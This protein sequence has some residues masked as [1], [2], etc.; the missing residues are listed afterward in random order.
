MIGQS[1]QACAPA[2]PPAVPPPPG[3]SVPMS[4]EVEDILKQQDA[5]LKS[6]QHQIHKLLSAQNSQSSATQSQRATGGNATQVA[7]V[8]TGV[9]LLECKPFNSEVCP[10]LTTADIFNV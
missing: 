9:S 8:N 10:L 7:A 5:Q 3:Y 2:T 6:L 4:P 1:A